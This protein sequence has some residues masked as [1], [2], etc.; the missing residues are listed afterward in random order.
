MFTV[1]KFKLGCGDWPEVV[2]ALSALATPVARV[3]FDSAVLVQFKINPGCVFAAHVGAIRNQSRCFELARTRCALC[4][5]GSILNL[6]GYCASPPPNCGLVP[7]SIRPSNLSF[8][9]V[10]RVQSSPTAQIGRLARL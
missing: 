6:T 10:E 4:C 9:V 7:P 3:D 8:L 5:P 2:A 1:R